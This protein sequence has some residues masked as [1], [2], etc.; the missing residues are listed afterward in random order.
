MASYLERYLQGECIQVWAELVA[1]GDQIQNEPIYSDAWAVA[2]E[3]MRRV[4]QNIER[5]IPRLRALGYVFL[6]DQL[7]KE[8]DFSVQGRN[9]IR[10]LPPVRSEP[11]SDIVA[12]LDALEREVGPLPL[13]LRAFYQEVGGVNFIGAAGWDPL[14]VFSF[15]RELVE[16]PDE[17]PPEESD[18]WADGYREEEQP[19]PE[20]YYHVVIAPDLYHKAGVGGG[21][22][23]E[24]RISK[25]ATADAV[26]LNEEHHTTFVNYLRL[27]CL[28]AGFPALEAMPSSLA[29]HLDEVQRDMIP[30]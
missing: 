18:D 25:T 10:A 12:R 16:G 19:L 20:K 21:S 2:C 6:H 14:V 22:P 7:P 15:D 8:R 27:C 4:R 5:M 3:T 30:F 13:S 28:H 24:I 1:L 17:E 26:L 29:T 9:W 23:Y 11:S